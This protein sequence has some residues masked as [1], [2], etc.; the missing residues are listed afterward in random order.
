MIQWKH[1]P[2]GACP[3]QSEG[4]FL[5]YY[6]YFRARYDKAVIEFSLTE[7]GWENDMIHGRYVLWTT[8]SLYG[9]GWLP[10][11]FCRMLVWW[12]CVRFLFK[13]NKKSII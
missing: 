1:K 9:A 10:K 6:F 3:V 11:W 13:R 7:P 12:G 2:S 5:G 8:R 4:Y